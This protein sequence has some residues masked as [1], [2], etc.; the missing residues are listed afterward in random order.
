MKC[1]ICR[2]ACCETFTTEIKMF[3]PMPDAT[4]WLE[5]HAVNIDG[6]KLTFDAKC[7]KLTSAGRCAIWD[8]RPLICELYIAGGPQCLETVKTRRSPQQYQEI[9]E[10]GDPQWL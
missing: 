4:R 8:D 5:L 7:V 10:E 9:R 6:E 3:P 2:G 1:V